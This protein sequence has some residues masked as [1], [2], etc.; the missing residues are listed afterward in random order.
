MTKLSSFFKLYSILAVLFSAFSLNAQVLV[1]QN[2]ESCPLGILPLTGCGSPAFMPFAGV[3]E[4]VNNECTMPTNSIKLPIPRYGTCDGNENVTLGSGVFVEGNFVPGTYR[5][6]YSV[7]GL[8]NHI[9]WK[10]ANNISASSGTPISGDLF[11][12]MPCDN[13]SYLMPNWTSANSA[14]VD[15]ISGPT[16]NLTSII[17]ITA[18]FNRLTFRA[19]NDPPGQTASGTSN[20]S[21]LYLDNVVVERLCNADFKFSV[22]RIND[23]LSISVVSSSSN[24]VNNWQVY[25]MPS[26]TLIYNG[27]NG[28]NATFTVALASIPA[29]DNQLR[30]VHNVENGTLCKGTSE[31]LFTIPIYPAL[32]STFTATYTPSSNSYSVTASSSQIG[33]SHS[34]RV[35]RVSPLTVICTGT[36]QN[37]VCNN[38][39]YNVQY[40][41]VHTVKLTGN[42]CYERTSS[43]LITYNKNGLA[44]VEDEIVTSDANLMIKKNMNTNLQ[45]VELKAYPS[46]AQQ[47]L[48]IE[49]TVEENGTLILT[50][51]LGQLVFQSSVSKGYNQ[52]SLETLNFQNGIYVLTLTNNGKTLKTEKII[53]NN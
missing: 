14:S 22:C 12:K 43:Q 37:I 34:W 47:N 8:A 19:Y 3:P 50:N 48:N 10:F 20:C 35:E 1:N 5:I 16:L 17:T 32:N 51:S 27:N 28:N 11:C 13:E 2:F 26:N 23:N 29:G 4:V 15:Y 45:D 46:P 53:I 39:L 44:K 41:I 42:L 38:L 9:A 52:L 49:T 7:C 40:R 31:Q 6:T 18:P 24:T 25:S 21:S 36:G 30:I 33:V